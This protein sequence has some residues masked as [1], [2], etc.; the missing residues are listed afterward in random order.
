MLPYPANRRLR[1]ASVVS[2]YELACRARQRSTQAP[3]LPTEPRL[4]RDV[5][6]P[7]EE[8]NY[9]RISPHGLPF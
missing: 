2:L 9:A 8:I 5:G 7:E 4:R 3:Q 1:L 6:L